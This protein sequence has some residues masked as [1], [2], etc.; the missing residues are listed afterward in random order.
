MFLVTSFIGCR[1]N[2]PSFRTG[3]E[4]KLPP[5]FNIQLIDSSF[6]N[7][8]A[9]PLGQ[10]FV[11]FYFSPRC[12]YCRDQMEELIEEIS[13]LKDIRFYA[14]TTWPFAEIKNFYKHYQLQKFSNIVVGLDYEN[15]FVNNFKAP[16]VPFIAIYGKDGRLKE[17]MVGKTISKQIIE[18][19]GS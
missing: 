19:A 16:G 4:G 7:T 9:I 8:S 3:L 6:L 15:F 11:F 17:A 1:N 13:S 5:K 2:K 12:P 10:P 14:L 18:I